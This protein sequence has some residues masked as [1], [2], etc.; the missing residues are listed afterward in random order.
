MKKNIKSVIKNGLRAE[1]GTCVSFCPERAIEM[2]I[3]KKQGVYILNIDKSKCNN[4]GICLKNL[5]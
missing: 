3:D 1:C 5:L 4:C 2:V